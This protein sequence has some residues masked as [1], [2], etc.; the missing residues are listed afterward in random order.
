MIVDFTVS[1]F[2]SFKDEQTFSLYTETPGTHLLDNISY[3]GND[4]IGLLKSAG[5]Y[6][7]NASGKSN[8]INGT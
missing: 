5:L 6:G 3:P 1:N 8:L 7:A 4:K 2:R